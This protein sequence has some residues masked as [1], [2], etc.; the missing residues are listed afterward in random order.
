MLTASLLIMDIYNLILLLIC[1]KSSLA[2]GFKH[3]HGFQT[4]NCL[5]PE[6]AESLKALGKEYK[7]KQCG[8][9]LSEN[10]KI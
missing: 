4:R 7:L 5:P 1:I 9:T 2:M 6:R 10:R 3:S 8:W